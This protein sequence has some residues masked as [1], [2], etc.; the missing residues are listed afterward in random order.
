[1]LQLALAALFSLD[2]MNRIVDVT[3]AVISPDGRRI[4]YLASH[5]VLDRNVEID[6]LHVIDV[7]TR[8][9][10]AIGFQHESYSNLM[11]SNGGQLAFVAD[12]KTTGTDQ[13][14]VVNEATGKEQRVTNGETDV[15]DAAWSPDGRRIAFVRRDYAPP[16]T[17]AAAFGDAFEVGDNAYLA[18]K[19]ALPARLF[20]TSIDG[21]A[22]VL[23]S[24]TWSVRDDYP[25]WTNDGRSIV[26]ARAPNGI[27]GDNELA[28]LERVDVVTGARTTLTDRATYETGPL[29]APSGALIAFSYPHEGDPAGEYEAF[30]AG[31]S[32]TSVRSLSAALDRHVEAFAWYDASHVLLRVYDRTRVR[33]IVASLHGEYDELPT[34]DAADSE[35]TTQ[36]VARDGGVVFTGST[37]KRPSELYYLPAHASA[38]VRLTHW[39]D[40][41]AALE[42]ASQT[43]L[44]YANDGFKQFAVLTYPPHYDPHKKYPMVLRI[45][46]GPALTSLV[47]FDPFY[48][49]AAARGYIVLAP[50]YRGSTDFGNAFEHAIFRDASAGPGRDVMAAIDM[51]KSMNI[52]DPDRIGVSG[53]SY[54]GQMTTWMIGHYDIFKAAVTGAAVND[55]VVDYA[56]ADDVVDD[57][58]SFGSS[59]NDPGQIDVWR[60]QSPIEFADRIKTPTLIL[61]NVYDVRVPIVENYELFRALRDRGVPVKFYAY[62]TGGHLPDGPVRYADAYRRWLDWF[63]TYLRP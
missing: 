14:F 48:Q 6:V 43:E 54:G 47:A 25:A 34:G 50:N 13:I 15:L 59:P 28:F 3:G 2:A 5:N 26:Y 30:L 21:H 62:P 49:L 16:K 35:I 29:V 38:P 55:L 24:G 17:G 61:S 11:W 12:D 7:Q 33:L 31:E 1:M 23:T 63:D 42:L 36:C 9:D 44:E 8:S 22:K 40:E 45:H 57:R 56:I 10:R 51:V 19:S 32:G 4:A 39:N 52:I 46:G 18:T 58:A 53:W 37:P 41:I 60:A 27:Y 20:V